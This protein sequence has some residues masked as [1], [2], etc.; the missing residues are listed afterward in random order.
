ML[1]EC[2]N[3][4]KHIVYIIVENI[5]IKFVNIKKMNEM[6]IKADKIKYFEYFLSLIIQWYR[7]AYGSDKELSISRVTA[8]K[9]LFLCAAIKNDVQ[10]D[11]LC[12]FNKFYA[13]PHGP[14]ESD[15]YN[16]MVNGRC[17]NYNF[18]ST[19]LVEN[20]VKIHYDDLDEQIKSR[21]DR[22]VEAL[23]KENKNLIKLHAFQLVEIT[24]KWECWKQAMKIAAVLNKGSYTMNIESIRNSNAIF[25]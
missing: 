25:E 7:S 17:V 3:N 24:H 12:I 6:Y 5:L 18:E 11:L 8:L 21:I 23:K 13:L 19:Y 9:L 2:S 20:N 10:E 22:S 1:G 16:A 4:H 14:V 15:I